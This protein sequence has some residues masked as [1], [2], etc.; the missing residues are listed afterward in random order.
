MQ[1]A[2][3]RNSRL[4]QAIYHFIPVRV[5]MSDTLRNMPSPKN[6]NGPGAVPCLHGE[7][8]DG[9]AALELGDRGYINV[10]LYLMSVF[11][12]V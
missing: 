4:Q 7:L 8:Q 9:L 10:S 1:H 2:F 5:N 6:N 11:N 12:K 3:N